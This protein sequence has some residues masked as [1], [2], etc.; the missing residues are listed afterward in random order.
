MK[1]FKLTSNISSSLVK[2][3]AV[4]SNPIRAAFSD[5]MRDKEQAEERF[6]FD[7]EE[8]KNFKKIIF[9]KNV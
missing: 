5:K 8:S 6:Y 7:K 4:R 2:N 3:L 9:L 1:A